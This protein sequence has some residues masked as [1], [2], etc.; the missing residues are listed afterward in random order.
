MRALILP[1]LPLKPIMRV[2]AFVLKVI[3]DCVFFFSLF[4]SVQ[5]KWYTCANISDV[6]DSKPQD[7]QESRAMKQVQFLTPPRRKCN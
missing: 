5:Y 4:L 6:I 1:A 3:A 2:V 7:L